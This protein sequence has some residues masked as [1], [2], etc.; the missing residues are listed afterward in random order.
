M[1]FAEAERHFRTAIARLE[2]PPH[3]AQGREAYY[4]LGLALKAQGPQ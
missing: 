3:H 1:Q 2:F 4:Y